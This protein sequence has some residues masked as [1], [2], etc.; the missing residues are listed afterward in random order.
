MSCDACHPDGGDGG[1]FYAKNH[2]QRLYRSP[3][4]R[5][6]RET[7]PYFFPAA[8]PSLEVTAAVVLRRNRFEN[9]VPTRREIE[10][11]AAFQ[12]AIVALPN[13]NAGARGEWADEMVLPDGRRGSPKRGVTLFENKAGCA[14]RECH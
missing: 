4:L 14:T 1:V 12:R 10:A 2:P 8:F 5:D 13:P 7:P 9:P 11:L 3:A 6:A